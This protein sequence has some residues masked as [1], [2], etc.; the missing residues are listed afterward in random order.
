[1]YPANLYLLDKAQALW[2]VYSDGTPIAWEATESA[3]RQKAR[4]HTEETGKQCIIILE[5]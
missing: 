2:V 3:A 5:D 4:E 1:M